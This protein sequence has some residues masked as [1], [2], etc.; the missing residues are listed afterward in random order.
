MSSADKIT[1]E[2]CRELTDDMLK[3][4]QKIDEEAV[5]RL[6]EAKGIYILTYSGTELGGSL[7]GAGAPKIVYVSKCKVDSDRHFITGNTGYSTIRR[8]IAALLES[9]MGL[10]PIPRSNDVEDNDRYDNFKLDDE[11]EE[12]LSAWIFDNFSIAFHDIDEDMAVDWQKAMIHYAIPM[13]NFQS[14]PENK[15]GAEIK[16]CRKRCAEAARQN[17]KA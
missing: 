1:W 17:E 9:K 13:L 14:N 16:V 8:S 10:T 15:Y 5:K 12:K 2:Q 3:T 7:W 11:G 4:L 6:T